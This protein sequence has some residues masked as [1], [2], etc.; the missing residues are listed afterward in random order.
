LTS[1]ENVCLNP[2]LNLSASSSS[3]APEHAQYATPQL[4]FTKLTRVYM[5]YLCI[6]V[7]LAYALQRTLHE[8]H[9]K[10]NCCSFALGSN[11]TFCNIPASARAVYA[12]RLNPNKHILS[13]A[14]SVSNLVND[15]AVKKIS[16][17]TYSYPSESGIPDGHDRLMTMQA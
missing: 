8:T 1:I 16:A 7:C 5:R 3:C 9:A 12:P 4:S 6:K 15:V 2:W 11:P 17:G 13:P 10:G 14:V